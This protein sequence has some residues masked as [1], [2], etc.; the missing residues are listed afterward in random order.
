MPIDLIHKFIPLSSL[1]S[2]FFTE[3]ATLR[4]FVIFKI[5]A[6]I[7]SYYHDALVQDLENLPLLS[8]G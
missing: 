2:Q 4:G 8:R 5:S 1:E 7:S 6:V 3:V